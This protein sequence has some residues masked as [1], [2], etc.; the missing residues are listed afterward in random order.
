MSGI[1]NFVF[2]VMLPSTAATGSPSVGISK[3]IMHHVA[4]VE[5][6]APVAAS[7][8]KY[9]QMEKTWGSNCNIPA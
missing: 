7:K 4:F 1:S 2:F 3:R 6:Y 5:I 8:V 9:L